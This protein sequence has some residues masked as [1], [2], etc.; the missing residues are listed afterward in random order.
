MKIFGRVSMLALLVLLVAASSAMAQPFELKVTATPLRQEVLYPFRIRI[1]VLVQDKATGAP[2][3]TARV[4]I[5][6]TTERVDGLPVGGVQRKKTKANGTARFSF[7][8]YDDF[9]G[10]T[11][12]FEIR[13]EKREKQGYTEAEATV[14][15][16]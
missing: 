7:V 16:H 11:F 10:Q 4:H 5:T 12:L 1:D 3:D 15:D 14:I 13:A 2:V 6:Y 8:T 9:N